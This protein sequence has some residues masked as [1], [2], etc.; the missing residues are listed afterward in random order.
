MAISGSALRQLHRI[1]RQLTDLRERL[2]RGPKQIAA[3]E[4]IVKRAE[5][6][7]AAAKASHRQA[8]ITADDK[9]LQLKSREARM[10]DLKVKLNQAQSNREF[11]ALKE[12]IAADQQANSVL[13]DEILEA[14]EKIDE[15][16]GGIV[17][18][19]AMLK[20]AIEEAAK[21]RARINEA[22]QGLEM[23]LSRVMAELEQAET[24]LPD[25]FKPEYIRMTKAKGE[26]AMAQVEG[27]CC[28]ECFQMITANME[29]ELRLSKPIFCKSCGA[30]MYLSDE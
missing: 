16:Q 9:Q 27:G 7:V 24:A 21:V 30:L 19:E 11:Q 18:A 20:K 29:N 14:M 15:L 28:G 23:E 17:T 26:K 22:Q 3:G 12:Q 25:D 2:A 10:S 13:A 1:H 4:M 6:D 8:R 5:G